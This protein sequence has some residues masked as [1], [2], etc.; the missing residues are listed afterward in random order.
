VV[1]GAA[2]ARQCNR[3][4]DDAGVTRH[5]HSILVSGVGGFWL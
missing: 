5:F 2:R 1:Q 3:Q 4:L